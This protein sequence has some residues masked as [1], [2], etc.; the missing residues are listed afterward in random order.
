LTSEGVSLTRGD[1]VGASLGVTM[2][3]NYYPQNGTIDM[4]GVVSPFYLINGIG[5]IL[6]R[7]GEGVFGFTYHLHGNASAPKIN[8]NPLSLLTP[9]MFRDIFRRA[10]PKTVQ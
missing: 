9:G 2:T 10:P 1:A 5:Q 7:R 8:I 3:G 4:R 6:T